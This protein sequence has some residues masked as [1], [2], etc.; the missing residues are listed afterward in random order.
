[1]HDSDDEGVEDIGGDE[2]SDG[3]DGV[4]ADA[5]GDIEVP[6]GVLVRE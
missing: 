3:W 6:A 4:Y 2:A 5:D 1:M